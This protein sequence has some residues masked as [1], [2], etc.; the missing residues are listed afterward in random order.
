MRLAEKAIALISRLFNNIGMVFLSF[1]ML[2]ITADVF[3]R[4]AFNHP[5]R[6]ANELAEF[7]MLL[8][9]FLAIAYTQHLKSNISVNILYERFPRAAKVIIDVFV[10]LLCLGICGL[11]LWQAFVYHNYLSEIDRASLILKVPLA[12]FQ[13]VMIV[14]FFMLCLVLIFDLIH[15]LR[16]AVNK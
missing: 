4:I 10:Y 14:G 15:A 13:L 6:G 11:I 8:V 1:L 12:P 5:I 16:K 3:L 9:V 7:I 2:V